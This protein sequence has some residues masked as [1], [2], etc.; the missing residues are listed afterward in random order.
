MADEF[1]FVHQGLAVQ[2][3]PID[4]RTAPVLHHEVARPKAREVVKKVRALAQLYIHLGQR[5]LD[6]RPGPR[7]LTP[8]D[9]DA[10]RWMGTA[11]AAE[12][13]QQEGPVLLLQFT[14]HRPQLL[15]D[16][17]RVQWRKL[18]EPHENNI[19]YVIRSA[20]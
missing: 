9:G 19:L 2:P 20:V 3:I 15:S 16:G 13:N 5:R 18:V 11:P 6:D 12:S 4:S 14:V 8:V 7:D 1:R 10:E 17:R